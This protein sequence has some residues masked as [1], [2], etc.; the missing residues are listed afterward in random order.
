M[1][2]T[3]IDVVFIAFVA[4]GAWNAVSKGWFQD[5]AIALWMLGIGIIC[6]YEMADRSWKFKLGDWPRSL[7][8]LLIAL[9]V[10]ATIYYPHIKS[11]WG[12]GAPIRVSLTFTKDSVVLANQRIDCL[13]ID[14]T[15]S[16]FYVVGN[17]DQHA[18]FIP[19]GSVGL[20]HFADGEKKSSFTSKE[21]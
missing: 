18:T 16:G 15:D 19:R 9:L 7:I 14:E 1:I 5:S 17:G 8:F 20:I 4:Q 12:G 2:H 6:L 11:S 21:K 3:I 13:L 10:F